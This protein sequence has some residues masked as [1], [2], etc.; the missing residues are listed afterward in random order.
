MFETSLQYW[1]ISN[2]AGSDLKFAQAR[3]ALLKA[4]HR[5]RRHSTTV[6]ILKTVSDSVLG[7]L[8]DGFLAPRLDY[9]MGAKSA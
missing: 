8:I 6:R 5:E 4:E 7:G 9:R 1:N 2:G 3:H